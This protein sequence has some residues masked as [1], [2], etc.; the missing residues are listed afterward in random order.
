MKRSATTF[1]KCGPALAGLGV[2]PSVG[3][4][5]LDHPLPGLP[6]RDARWRCPDG[7]CVD[8]SGRRHAGGPYHDIG[9]DFFT[10]WSACSWS[11]GSSA[12]TTCLDYAT[13]SSLN[14]STLS[15]NVMSGM[16]GEMGAGR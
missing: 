8:V 16:P 1:A 14:R 11:P 12:G 5:Y 2:I 7:V 13:G 3:G 10:C 6:A 4:F 9:I 15:R